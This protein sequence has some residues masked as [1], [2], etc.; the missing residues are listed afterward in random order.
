MKPHKVICVAFVVLDFVKVIQTSLNTATTEGGGDIGMMEINA[1]MSALSE[2][3]F[4][5]EVH[6]NSIRL[7]MPV[8]R[9]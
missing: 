3:T 9:D 7:Q 8:I 2:S 6:D 4:R 1:C 5:L